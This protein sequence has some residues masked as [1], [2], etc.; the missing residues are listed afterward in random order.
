MWYRMLDIIAD[1]DFHALGRIVA[2]VA[3]VG[4]AFLL[5]WFVMAF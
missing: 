4:A 1:R 3:L 2:G 5:G